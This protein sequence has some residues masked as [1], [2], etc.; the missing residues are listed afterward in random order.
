MSFLIRGE[1]DKAGQDAARN[2]GKQWGASAKG[3]LLKVTSE[4]VEAVISMKSQGEKINR[5]ART[6]NLSRQTI[7]RVLERY[8]QGRI[9]FV[10]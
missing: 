3:R 6:V 5:I 10:G 7:Y 2:A 4:Q 1:Q 9:D 8:E